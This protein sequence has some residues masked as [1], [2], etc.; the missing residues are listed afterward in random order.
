MGDG[1]KESAAT[2]TS[3]SVGSVD[4]TSVVNHRSKNLLAC[5]AAVI[6]ALG[7]LAPRRSP[8]IRTSAPPARLVPLLHCDCSIPRSTSSSPP[9]SNPPGLCVCVPVSRRPSVFP[10]AM[11]P[12]HDHA[13]GDAYADGLH[14]KVSLTGKGA[15][16]SSIPE[17][18]VGSADAVLEAMG[19]APE[20]SR[21]RSTL[22]VAFM[23]FV[24]AAIP[25]GL[26]TTFYY[27]LVGGGPSNI[28]WGWVSV[29][30]IILCVAA[31]LGEITS[32]YPTAGGTA[33]LISVPPRL[34]QLT[35]N[36]RRLLSDIHAFS[37]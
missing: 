12:L 23:S 16:R 4:V 30:F 36:A 25:Y 10:V 17:E 24:L 33:A 7:P 15:D 3:W 5:P 2:K 26:A 8:A 37:A 28:I 34:H 14:R 22:Q 9:P 11:A 21:N 31:S 20:L 32:V 27:P 29:S 19:Y 18:Q 1:P 35:A 6:S 13:P